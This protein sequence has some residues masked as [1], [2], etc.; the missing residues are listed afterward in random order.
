MSVTHSSSRPRA[1]VAG[2]VCP[3]HCCL[4]GRARLVGAASL[5]AYAEPT[6]HRVGGGERPRNKSPPEGSPKL[7][8]KG[9]LTWPWRM[10]DKRQLSAATATPLLCPSEP[11][12]E[13]DARLGDTRSL[14]T[15]A[16]NRNPHC[17]PQSST[18]E[19][20]AMSFSSGCP[21]DYVRL[22]VAGGSQRT[23]RSAPVSGD[24]G[25]PTAR[26]S[27]PIRMSAVACG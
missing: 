5:S 14:S 10:L 12:K 11:A 23:S 17:P 13:G 9:S 16:R 18:S 22:A 15:R 6:W 3:L 20:A 27:R 19:Q 26:Q 1:P 4:P 8:D 21:V 2:S 7:Q 24:Q 25:G